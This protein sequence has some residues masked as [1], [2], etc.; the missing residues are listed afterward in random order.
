MVTTGK[1]ID[2]KS[3]DRKLIYKLI[4]KMNAQALRA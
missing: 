4:E 2:R 1:S 3:I